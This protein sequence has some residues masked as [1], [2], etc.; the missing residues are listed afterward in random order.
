MLDRFI[1]QLQDSI[2]RAQLQ[3][4]INILHLAR[5]RMA[6]LQV[7]L[8][9]LPPGQQVRL[10][11]DIDRSLPMEWPLWMEACRCDDGEEIAA[12]SAQLH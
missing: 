5:H 1:D 12:E 10:Q 8:L 9:S 11:R 3:E 2:D 7:A 6:Q 4:D